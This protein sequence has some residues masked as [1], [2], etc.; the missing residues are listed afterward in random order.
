MTKTNKSH[1]LFNVLEVHRKN[2]VDY[3]Y[4]Q[5]IG[6]ST[7]NNRRIEIERKAISKIKQQLEGMGIAVDNDPIDND[8]DEPSMSHLLFAQ[9]ARPTQ[10]NKEEAKMTIES[11]V[12][13]VIITALSK[14]RDAVLRHLNSVEEITVKDRT[15]YKSVIQH[16][17]GRDSCTTVVLSLPNMGNTEAAIATTQAITIWNPSQVIAVG[18]A[19][20]VKKGESRYL[21][22]IIVADQI[23]GYEPG[24]ITDGKTER[25][26]QVIRPAYKLIETARNLR[27][28]EWVFGATKSR[29]DGSSGRTVPNVHFGVVASGEKVVADEN[30]VK[31][32]QS[33]WSQLI[34]I[35]MEGY[36][37][38]LAAFEAE[39]VPGM[40][41]V[42]GICDWA[43]A[44]KKDEWQE[45]AADITAAFI[46]A[47]L[48]RIYLPKV[49]RQAVRNE[50]VQYTGTS[51]FKFCER[52]GD[53]WE[54]L[55]MIFEIPELDRSRF[56]QGFECGRIWDWIEQRN[57]MDGLEQALIQ[58]HREDLIQIL[59]KKK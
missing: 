56:K 33:S 14:E 57:K 8:E 52:L 35:E 4:Q 59:E 45:Y 38:G 43:D 44:S 26:F 50:P 25:R 16:E 3:L 17:N 21:G 20:G 11:P 18:I 37:V 48:K 1:P 15:Y 7:E 2:V 40:L 28:E 58:I 53:S 49:E 27:P 47:L 32:L 30:L 41:L 31:E 46:V 12:D 9:D 42:K 5:A 39:T 13:V 55:A 6:F 36:G 51:K 22:D 29:P 34:G 54:A 10:N 19:G 23:V 24:R